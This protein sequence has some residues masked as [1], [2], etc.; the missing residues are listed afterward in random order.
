[1]LID[2]GG[3]VRTS[4]QGGGDPTLELDDYAYADTYMDDLV[5][6]L[7]AYRNDVPIPIGMAYGSS[8]LTEENAHTYFLRESGRKL[9]A[10][11]LYRTHYINEFF[12]RWPS[13]FR[14]EA[15]CDRLL[16]DAPYPDYW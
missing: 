9:E 6:I 13:H 15:I 1:V 7:L 14:P 8:S 12:W 3:W 4:A 16:P 10:D 11:H 2:G 5:S